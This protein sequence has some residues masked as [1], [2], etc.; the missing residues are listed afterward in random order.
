ML[1]MIFNKLHNGRSLQ[2]GKHK[3]TDAGASVPFLVRWPDGAI[4]SKKVD[5][6]IDFSDIL[7]TFADISVAHS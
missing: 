5:A 6:P 3:L 7:P 1:T 2:G 4:Q